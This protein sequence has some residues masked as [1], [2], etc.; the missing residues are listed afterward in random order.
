MRFVA[1]LDAATVQTTFTSLLVDWVR[2]P[3]E[4]EAKAQPDTFWC[5]RCDFPQGQKFMGNARIVCT[6][7]LALTF[8]LTLGSGLKPLSFQGSLSRWLWSVAV[9]L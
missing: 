8:S 9:S 1:T 5:R 6:F 3:F 4:V 7:G 2:T